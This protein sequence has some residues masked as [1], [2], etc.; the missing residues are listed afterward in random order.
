MRIVYAPGKLYKP[1]KILIKA[2]RNRKTEKF[3]K[4][5]HR[6]PG[7]YA[8]QPPP[9]RFYSIM[10]KFRVIKNKQEADYIS[11]Q[12]IVVLLPCMQHLNKKKE[13]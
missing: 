4:K 12:Q 6:R 13:K 10:R 3:H 2:E 11:I 8:F 1:G 9:T 7:V 5:M